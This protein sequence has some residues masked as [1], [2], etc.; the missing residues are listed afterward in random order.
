MSPNNLKKSLSTPSISSQQST[1]RAPLT[2]ASGYRAAEAF[3][4]PSPIFTSGNLTSSG[5]NLRNVTFTL[6][7]ECDSPTAE[8]APT[9]IFLPEFHFPRDHTEVTVSGGKWTISLD[10][11]DDAMIQ[12]LRWW[13]GEGSQHMSGKGVARGPGLSLAPDDEAGYYEQ[14]QP[15]K[16]TAM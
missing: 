11:V 5:F 4:R 2:N 12:K 14:C 7:L 3:V 9:E 16:C 6:A 10:G 15:S 8:E 13:H 1:S